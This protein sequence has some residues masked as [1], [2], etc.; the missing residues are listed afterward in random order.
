MFSTQSFR[1]LGLGLVVL[2]SFMGKGL[3]AASLEASYQYIFSC[4]DIS[5]SWNGFKLT[6]GSGS[7]KDYI[8]LARAGTPA[9][10]TES[11]Y[12]NISSASGESA[13]PS[14]GLVPAKQYILRGF[15]SRKKLLAESA[16][17]ELVSD[18][19]CA[20]PSVRIKRYNPK[21]RK[22][23]VEYS[24]FPVKDNGDYHWFAIAEK[25]AP[26]SQYLDVVSLRNDKQK[27]GQVEL[28]LVK[29]S[30]YQELELRTYFSWRAGILN[31][32]VA[33]RED[34]FPVSIEPQR[35]L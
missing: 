18:Y 29:A 7:D 15:N 19:G 21:T 10:S 4:E 34:F 5:F 31:Y 3:S 1:V 20:T 6:G 14:D 13:F 16:P 28:P 2:F 33:L 23:I 24:G 30:V 12:L 11:I 26:N 8:T 35:L 27:A 17:F 32:R 25:G 22:L 9:E